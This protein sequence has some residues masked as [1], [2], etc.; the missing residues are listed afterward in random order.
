MPFLDLV[1]ELAGTLPGLS[2]LLAQ[3]Y[4]N[5]AWQQ[6][7]SERLW[8]FLIVDGIVICPT[9]ITTGSAAIIQ[10][11]NTATLSVAASAV[12]LPFCG[13]TPTLPGIT[14]MAIRFGAASPA[15]GQ[16]YSIEA[17]DITTPTAIILTLNRVV[18]EATNALS[19]IQVYRPYIVPPVDDFLKWESLVDM[20][21]AFTIA[22]D[23]LNKTSKYFDLRDPQRAAQGLAYFCGNYMGAWVPDPVTGTVVSNANVNAG[24]NIYELWPHPTNGQTFYCRFRRKG[25]D[26]LSPGDTQPSIIPDDLIIQRALGWHAYPFAMANIA[27]FPTF[28]GANW[29]QLILVA[30]ASYMESLTDTK[31]QD[32]EAAPQQ[33][34]NRGHGLRVG[35]GDFKGISDFPIDSNYLQSHLVRF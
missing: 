32:E 5:R 17:A 31:R 18:V 23:R 7:R 16:I 6:V 20:T 2:P 34:W 22:N 24:S 21:N 12:I 8:S 3:K 15:I 26:F 11:T 9:Q 35:Y 4:I 14:N 27:N 33:V 1:S 10:Y 28:K 29:A 19:G 13:P 25:T 30:K